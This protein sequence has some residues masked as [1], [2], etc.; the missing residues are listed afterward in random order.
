MSEKFEADYVIIGGGT[1][2]S[3]LAARLASGSNKRVIL[4]ERGRNDLNRWIH[5]PATFFRVLPSPDADA[6][7]S[8]PDDTLNGKPFVVPQ[9]RVLGGGSSI[10]GMIY[11]RG[12]HQDYDDWENLDG[13]KGWS[14]S[15]VLPTFIKQ[16]K[17]TRIK[18]N[19]HGQNGKLIVSDPSCPHPLSSALI[20]ASVSA[21]IKRSY[22]FNGSS[23]D[24]VGW[25]QVNAYK[26]KRQSAATCF[27]KPEKWRENL[28]IFTDLEASRICFQNRKAIHVEAKDQF[29]KDYCIKAKNEIILTSGSFHSPKLLMLSGIGPANEL[30][31]HGIDVIYDSNEVGA[32]YQDHVGAPVTRRL[33]NANGLYGEDKGLKALKN[34]FNYFILNKGLLTS[35]LLQA[36]ACVDSNGSGRPDIQYNFA[37]FAPGLPGDPPLPFH[38]IQIHPMTMRPKSRGRLT[39]KSKNSYDDPRFVTSMLDKEADLDTLRRGVRIAQKIFDQPEIKDLV[40]EEIWP[41]PSVSTR[42]GS[43]TFD[44]AIRKQARTIFHPSGTCRMGPDKSS[45]VDLSLRVRGVE[46]LRVADCS[47]MPRLVS[48]NTNAPTMM[49]ADICADEILSG[50]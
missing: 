26:G 16:E 33:K 36:G 7:I 19:Y 24:G 50:H 30:L 47:I 42:V 43:N 17:N 34:S 15:K 39:L 21:G 32:N 35:N 14:Y 28:K 6:V 37:P 41:G 23:Q 2:G 29:G 40:G 44:D 11:M 8:E 5:I 4:L 18:D 3:I 45:V 38:A 12:Q 1:A 25:Y 9:G 13:C 27:L 22:D 31:R 10:N 49:I 20:N 46:G 48:G